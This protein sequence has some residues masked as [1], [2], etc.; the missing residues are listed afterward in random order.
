MSDSKPRIN[1]WSIYLIIAMMLGGLVVYYNYLQELQ[2]QSNN[3]RPAYFSAL[4]TDLSLLDQT[5]KEVQLGD[6]KGKVY[7]INYIFTRCPGQCVGVADVMQGHLEQWKGHP[8]FHM[9]SVSLDP[10]HDTPEDMLAFAMKNKLE[11]NQWW[12]LTGDEAA[13]R[14][15][16]KEYFKFNVRE[17]QPEERQSDRDLYDH[18]PLIALV[19][20]KARIRGV[21]SV[22]DE[23]RGEEFRERLE[24]DLDAVMKE[25]MEEIPMDS[26]PVA[27]EPKNWK[28]EGDIELVRHDG[29]QVNFSDLKGKVALLSHVFTRCPAQCPGICAEVSKV[30]EEFADDPRLMVASMTMDPGYDTPEVLSAFAER[31][32]LVAD[33]WWFLTGD[34]EALPKFMGEKLL[35]AQQI[36]PED[37]RIVPEDLYEHDFKVALMDHEMKIRDWYEMTDKEAIA[38][39]K[40]DLKEALASVPSSSE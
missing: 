21:Y 9:A 18:D 36:K 30:R 14:K 10:A 19:D 8:L 24:S 29:E 16:M 6:L 27:A 40:T 23:E 5:G 34:P 12:F 13:I 33:N 26:L 25:A 38:R 17:K 39:L 31:H 7:L 32:G 28:V 15:Y 2:R 11:S 20:H 3:D 4:E 1:P 37:Q 35:F 22:Y